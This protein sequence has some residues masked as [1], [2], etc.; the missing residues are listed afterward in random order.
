MSNELIPDYDESEVP[1][2][3]NAEPDDAA[4]EHEASTEEVERVLEGEEE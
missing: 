2:D 1:V 4:V 3:D